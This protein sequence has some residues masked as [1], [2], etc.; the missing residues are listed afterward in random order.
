M[1]AMDQNQEHCI[2]F[3]K[4]D[5]GTKGLYGN[6]EEKELI[7]ISRP[8]ILR[9]LKEFEE[10]TKDIAVLLYDM[11]S[12]VHL[13][14]PKAAKKFEEYPELQLQPYMVSQ[15]TTYKSCTRIDN[16]WDIYKWF[17]LKNQIREARST[18]LRDRPELSII[19]H[20]CY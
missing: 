6:P 12:I 5:G 11:P 13:I 15:L 18:A 14:G 10:K 16:V 9:A 4:D 17:S 2:Q 8:G 19:T 3:L 7:E 20:V 1:M